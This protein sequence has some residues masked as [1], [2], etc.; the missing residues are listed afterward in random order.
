MDIGTLFPEEMKMVQATVFELFAKQQAADSGT[1]LGE[2]F[3][4]QQLMDCDIHGA[5]LSAPCTLPLPAVPYP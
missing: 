5:S 3:S 1:I 2:S 4:S